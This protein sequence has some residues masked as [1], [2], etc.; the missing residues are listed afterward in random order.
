MLIRVIYYREI[1]QNNDV[2]YILNL[3][4]VTKI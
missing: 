2:L 1:N 3:E 4:L